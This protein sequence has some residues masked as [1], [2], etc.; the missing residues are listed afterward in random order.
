MARSMA[1]EYTR[2]VLALDPMP[3][4]LVKDYMEEL[5]PL[6]THVINLSIATGELPHEWKTALVVPLLKK[7]GLNPIL[8]NYRSVSNFQYVSKQTE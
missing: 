6:F 7:A 4:K 1:Y 3:T 5:L 2:L 8:K